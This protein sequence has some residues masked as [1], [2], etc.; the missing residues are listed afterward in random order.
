M[1]EVERE[2]TEWLNGE[3]GCEVPGP[4]KVHGTRW[5]RERYFR[6]RHDS[7]VRLTED[8]LSAVSVL[9]EPL[10]RPN[11]PLPSVLFFAGDFASTS[12]HSSIHEATLTGKY[13]RKVHIFVPLFKF[14]NRAGLRHVAEQILARF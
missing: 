7:S 10:P 8:E 2:L 13:R 4:I 9:E 3:L 6:G 12:F 11:G 1:Q 14:I 5:R